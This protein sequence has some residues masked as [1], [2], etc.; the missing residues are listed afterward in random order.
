MRSGFE[1]FQPTLILLALS[2]RRT[3][4][5]I[6]NHH[7]LGVCMCVTFELLKV[8]GGNGIFLFFSPHTS[9]HFFGFKGIEIEDCLAPAC[10]LLIHVAICDQINHSNAI[11]KLH[12][13]N[14]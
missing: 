10:C 12:Q 8:C 9:V 13:L 5:I 11:C 2:N 14:R 4:V 3:N 7:L 6:Y 1:G